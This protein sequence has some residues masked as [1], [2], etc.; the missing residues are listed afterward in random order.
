[1]LKKIRRNCFEGIYLQADE[2]ESS[3]KNLG[4][5]PTS[6]QMLVNFEPE[7][8]RS[9]SVQDQTTHTRGVQSES[10]IAGERSDQHLPNSLQAYE[11]IK[12]GEEGTVEID[13]ARSV[14]KEDPTSSLAYE[15][16]FLAK[17]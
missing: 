5:A 4:A 3:H 15:L 13:R 8:G 16:R 17:L 9:H 6:C 7:S 10:Y 1:M 11:G 14:G 2:E 12:R